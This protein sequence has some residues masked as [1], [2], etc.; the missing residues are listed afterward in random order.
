MLMDTG[1]VCC[2]SRGLSTSWGH[3]A[4]KLTG[5]VFSALKNIGGSFVAVEDG[6]VSTSLWNGQFTDHYGSELAED[7]AVKVDVRRSPQE[8]DD[9]VDSI[10]V[11]G[12]DAA[13]IMPLRVTVCRNRSPSNTDTVLE[14][15]GNLSLASGCSDSSADVAVNSVSISSECRDRTKVDL[16]VDR[17]NDVDD[18]QIVFSSGTRRKVQ[19]VKRTKGNRFFCYIW[20]FLNNFG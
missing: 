2:H 20:P 8:R 1:P 16:D 7:A 11:V 9:R 13:S 18:E 4:M 3:S 6:I 14:E 19:R 17:W 5:Q 10:P 15:L 12:L